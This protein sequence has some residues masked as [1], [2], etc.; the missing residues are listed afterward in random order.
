[1]ISSSSFL[2]LLVHPVD[3]VLTNHVGVVRFFFDLHFQPVAFHEFARLLAFFVQRDDLLHTIDGHDNPVA[4]AGERL[5]A[6]ASPLV[7][8]ERVPHQSL[9]DI[10]LA[11]E[12][13]TFLGFEDDV[14]SRNVAYRV[15]VR[16]QFV[17]KTTLELAALSRELGGIEG[18]ILITRR[19]GRY[20]LE[21]GEPGGTAKFT[22]TD[23]NAAQSAGFLPH[24]DLPHLDPDTELIGETLDEFSKI[25]ALF[26]SIVEGGFLAV[27]LEFDIAQLHVELERSMI[28]RVRLR[29]AG[30]LSFISHHFS[31]SPGLALR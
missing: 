9:E 1:M 14:R 3:P 16:I 31:T 12:R 6:F 27:A 13:A 25:D 2:L 23:T 28:S 7:L 21:I 20:G 15:H 29:V 22:A 30:S 24:A 11:V 5:F 4:F 8:A 18:K 19:A 10:G 17:V 26:S